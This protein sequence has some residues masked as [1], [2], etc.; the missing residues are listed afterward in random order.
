MTVDEITKDILNTVDET[1]IHERV[2]EAIHDYIDDGWEDEYDDIHEAYQETGRG[3]A[4]SQVLNEV[5]STWQ[6]D[7]G[8]E[9]SLDDFCDVF[10][11]LADEW[12]LTTN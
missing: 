8:V 9:L 5:L 1:T 3:E 6:N 2:S 7:N 12:C 10:E 11:R 4:D